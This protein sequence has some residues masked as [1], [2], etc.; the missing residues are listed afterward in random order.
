MRKKYNQENNTV[1]NNFNIDDRAVQNHAI[2]TDACTNGYSNAKIDFSK[3]S[4]V[5]ILNKKTS[6]INTMIKPFRF[7][8]KEADKSSL[9]NTSNYYSQLASNMRRVNEEIT[10]F[11][12]S[13]YLKEPIMNAIHDTIGLIEN[14]FESFPSKLIDALKERASCALTNLSYTYQTMVNP[15]IVF[16][17]IV[18]KV[19]YDLLLELREKAITSG[20]TNDFDSIV[21]MY[22]DPFVSSFATSAAS[23][24]AGAIYDGLYYSF[25]CD[26]NYEDFNI[27]CEYIKPYLLSFR[28]D[29]V[30]IARDLTIILVKH[31]L[32]YYPKKIIDTIYKDKCN[33]TVSVD[34]QST[35]PPPFYGEEK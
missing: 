23:I 3:D 30:R 24:M 17:Y 20:D 16:D 8:S 2:I 25:L 12:I 10:I 7:L 33:T 1:N 9:P 6:G 34:M 32:A 19:G 27:V 11:T 26:L 15:Q 5:D 21:T 4:F 22:S 31:R 29:M 13:S 14:E 28:D 18:D 35:L